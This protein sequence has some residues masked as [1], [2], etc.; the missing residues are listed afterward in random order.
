MLKMKNLLLSFLSIV[1]LLL[2]TSCSTEQDENSIPY[3]KEEWKG[4]QG[5]TLE[6]SKPDFIGPK[7]APKEAPNVLIVML[8]WCPAWGTRRT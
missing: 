2:I 6:D 5:K 4:V 1:M 7:K 3:P 8:P